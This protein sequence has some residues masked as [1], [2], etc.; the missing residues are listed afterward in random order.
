MM[1]HV[2]QRFIDK[3]RT[4]FQ[5]QQVNQLML[6]VFKLLKQKKKY[7]LYSLYFDYTAQTNLYMFSKAPVLVFCGLTWRRKP[8]NP[9]KT[10]TSGG[11]PLPCHI[12][13]PGCGDKWNPSL[14]Y[15]ISKVIL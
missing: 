6:G 4:L 12:L 1:N 15:L 9:E 2:I 14:N 8:E 13:M 7:K 10:T 11:W 5:S 3:I